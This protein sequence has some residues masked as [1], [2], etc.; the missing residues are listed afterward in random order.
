[1]SRYVAGVEVHLERVETAVIDLHT[2]S[3]VPGTSR[4]TFINAQESVENLLNCW[5]A[6]ITKSVNA[7]PGGDL[8]YVGV[9]IPGPFDYENGIA[10]MKNMGKFEALYGLNV[11]ELL[12]ERINIPKENIR[13]A[14][15]A[16]CFLHGEIVNGL[17]DGYSNVLGFILSAGLGSARFYQGVA[18]DA[19]LWKA[20]FKGSI[21]NDYLDNSW[22]ARR[23]AEFTGH[24]AKSIQE[25]TELAKT[26][27]GIG[28]LVFGEYGEN[29]AIFLAEYVKK[30][31]TDLVVVG[32]HNEAWDLFISHVKDRLQDK[33]INVPIR[34]AKL[35]DKA[36]VIGAGFLWEELKNNP[37]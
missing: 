37:A 20:H 23:Y 3:I 9:A 29:F 22:L 14:N 36:A 26:D 35:G 4:H 13:T 17:A 2:N 15:N 12:S 24:E 11:K 32:G 19:D 25:L 1:M 33:N 31:D 5:T 28:Q 18:T 27:D 16:P 6:S 10:L 34:A 7:H 21:A 30:F 8:K